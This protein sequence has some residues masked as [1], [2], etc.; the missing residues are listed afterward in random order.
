MWGQRKFSIFRRPRDTYI[1]EFMFNNVSWI[2]RFV[3]VRGRGVLIVISMNNC[4]LDDLP[5]GN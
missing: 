3:N 5:V 2:M 1:N 4:F